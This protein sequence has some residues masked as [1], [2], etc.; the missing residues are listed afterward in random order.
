M[1]YEDLITKP[2]VVLTELFQ[3]LLDVPTLKDTILEQRIE[4]QCS[5]PNNKNAVYKLKATTRNDLSRN[6]HMYSELQM[7]AL[8]E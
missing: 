7:Q 1:R 5:V 4:E 6:R 3:F 8:Q 2:K